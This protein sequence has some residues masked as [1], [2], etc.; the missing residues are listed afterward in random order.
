MEI[1]SSLSK[2]YKYRH[3]FKKRQNKM[4]KQLKKLIKENKNDE[5]INK[6][7]HRLQY[8]K[9][10]LLKYITDNNLKIQT[11]K[12]ELCGIFKENKDIRKL[13]NE[14]LNKYN[15]VSVFESSL[16]RII[17]IPINTLSKDI[18]I[19]KAYFFDILEDIIKNGFIYEENGKKEKYVFLTASAGQ[20]RTKKNVFIKESLYNKHLKTITCG[21]T[22]EDINNNG[23]MNI[24][25][26]LAYTALNNSATDL[27]KEF[28]I[29][30]AIV[31]PDFENNIST[32]V[33]KISDITY[34]IDEPV[35]Q[36][37]PIPHTDGCG[38]MLPSVNNKNT[39]I[40]LP[41]I[42]GLLINFDFKTFVQEANKKDKNKNYG[43]VTD[44]Y[45]KTYDI[46]KDDIQ[47]IFT[48]SQF[49]MHKF[50]KNWKDYKDKFKKYQCQASKCNEEEDEFDNAKINYQMLQTLVD[51]KDEEL[52][53]IC[54]NTINNIKSVGNNINT[55]LK[56]LG[57]STKNKRKNSL[58]MALNLYPEM[59]QD[60]YCKEIIKQV[61]KSMVKK[62]RAA[63]LVI[64]GTYTFISP[65]L[66][67]FCER[68]FLK[69]EYPKG[70]L[71]NGEVY[72]NIFK[73]NK[74]IDC[75][76]S[77]HLYMEHA[78]RNNIIDEEKSKWFT[79]NALYTSCHDP[80][81][82][83]LMFD[84]DGDK[85]LVC[86][87]DTIIRVAERNILEHN[88]VPLYYNM[89]KAK[90]VHVDSDSIYNGLITAYK[91][92][93]I[94]V[95]SNNITKIW[96]SNDD[97]GG[98]E[99]KLK[100]IKLLCLENNF[101]I[102][103]AKTLYK[104]TRPKEQHKL[105]SKYTKL[106][107]PHFFIYAKDKDIKQVEPLGH[108]TVDRL[109]KIIPNPN[110]SFQKLDLNK[111]DYKKLMCNK[112]INLNNNIIS[113]YRELD[114]KKPFLI[115]KEDDIE[116]S[117]IAYLYQDIKNQLIEFCKDEL[118]KGTIKE[119]IQEQYNN[120]NKDI[121]SHIIKC[122][123]TDVL[124]KY[125]YNEKNSKFKTTLWEC[126]GDIIYNNLLHNLKGTKVCEK[127]YKRIKVK[128]NRIKYCPE[129][130][131]E[132][133]IKKTIENRRKRNNCLK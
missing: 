60:V 111:F 47:I 52:T 103:Y 58:Q 77:P 86:V 79:T 95:I 25:K 89:Q 59:L 24:N 108:S 36:D 91:G 51:M 55:M 114:L 54:Q 26:Y 133:N 82:K 31:V 38:M 69:E 107:P 49:K 123:I 13:R 41:W 27:W 10:A 125:L 85:S 43:L 68:L 30:K 17:N 2:K 12:D 46:L 64:N 42:K 83:I 7:I 100:V 109:S 96:N 127:C 15:V 118:L 45:N 61:K 99:E 71:K 97:I 3:I 11:K 128:N 40:R 39:M 22:L 21:L 130:A 1:Y 6:T 119:Y 14:K 66:Y 101:V 53:T 78:I 72:C 92:G 88:I 131:K 115:N 80:I 105:I 90:P 33:Q 76:R 19:V 104:P 29:D 73:D 63:R 67:A 120:S 35:L 102:D 81:S 94:G 62:A 112:D 34:T 110:I 124:I 74:K 113:K 132:I 37:I 28:D 98:I 44:I 70:L 8:R 18:I 50:Y 93:N 122:Y 32:I 121:Q 126:F 16:T 56:V 48:E 23:G 57:V 87:D 5:K 75:L 116:K 4:E 84:V 9:D 106:K 65:D 20:I 129:C 117:N